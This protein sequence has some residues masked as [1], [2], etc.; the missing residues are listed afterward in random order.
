MIKIKTI[1]IRNFLSI[2]NV[3]QAIDFDRK[4]LTL[5][6]G[7]N[8]D[9]GGDD[10]GSRNGAGKSAIL[11]ALSYALYGQAIGD[12]K[13]DNLINRT[14]TKNM[15]VTLEFEHGTQVYRI[16]RG[17]RPKVMKYYVGDEEQKVHDDA[18]GDSRETQQEI[19]R[20]IGMSHDMFT[21]IIALNT[22]T[23]PF[24]SQKAHEQRD[25]I[26]Q[27]L[28]VTQLSEKAEKLKEQAKN[29][30]N[31]ITE[32]EYR[33]KGL[34]EANKKIEEQIKSLKNRQSIWKLRQKEDCSN[35]EKAIAALS[36]V[37]IDTEI[38]AH[39]DLAAYL[40]LNSKRE[41]L[42]NFTKELELDILKLERTQNKLKDEIASLKD[43]KC[44]ACG[45]NIHDDKQEEIRK[46]KQEALLET[47]LHLMSNL[48]QYEEYNKELYDMGEM[49]IKPD[50]FYSS[51]EEAL[52]HQ[53][54]LETLNK[55]LTD[56][57]FELDPYE[58]QL[59]EMVQSVSEEISYDKINDLTRLR[60]HQD[61]LVK[62]LTNKD[63]FIRKRIID[64]NLSY[65]NI[66]LGQYLDRLGLPHT[67]TFQ[68]DL[69]VNITELGRD[70]DFFNLSR[71]EMTRVSLA[72]SLAFRDMWEHLFTSYNLLFIDEMIDSGM[73]AAGVESAIAILKK[74][75]RDT[76][77]SVWLISHKD[78][79]SSRVNNIL[80]VVKENGFTSFAND[81]ED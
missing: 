51:M 63:S 16:E 27:L 39:R 21:H 65:L 78:E 72:L 4:D 40:V 7:E 32:E 33:I 34:V 44:Y 58:E 41:K 53:H 62:L 23:E 31:E 69:T 20:M 26:E 73:D 42:A 35:I 11:N 25:I 28:G 15:L 9:L 22:Y 76:N 24:L 56:R 74:M 18:Q 12:I 71:G 55:E 66:R 47:S 59:A 70:L 2:G 38:Q 60:D 10:A 14:N 52:K 45:Q 19:E 30:R 37:D 81:E 46:E 29:T 79:L 5:V 13:Q 1:T 67:V 50:T 77:K 17:R 43:H 75:S 3:T 57:R 49:E 68:N 64:Q 61:F 8:L 6:L 54:T 80:K 48:G 36:H